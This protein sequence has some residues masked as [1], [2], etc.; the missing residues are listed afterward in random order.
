MGRIKL[1]VCYLS[2]V[3]AY[4]SNASTLLT[5]SR[6]ENWKPKTL[7]D[8][9]VNVAK[10]Q[11]SVLRRFNLRVREPE[12]RHEALWPYRSANGHNH[13]TGPVSTKGLRD[14]RRRSRVDRPWEATRFQGPRGHRRR[15]TGRTIAVIPNLYSAKKP[16][17][18]L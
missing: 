2:Q 16:Y 5:S 6:V 14:C 18:S 4:T 8:R 13:G 17:L 1:C 7:A 11:A 3:S 10:S 12:K 15:E 9:F